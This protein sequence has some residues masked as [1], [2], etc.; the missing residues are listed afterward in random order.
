MIGEEEAKSQEDFCLAPKLLDRYSGTR[1]WYGRIT[2]S[3]TSAWRSGLRPALV[4][5]PCSAMWI[6]TRAWTRIGA[7]GEHSSGCGIESHFDVKTRSIGLA[8][9]L[10]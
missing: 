7:A 3:M 6:G 5:H 2:R 1:D 4:D 8:G 10:A 9:D